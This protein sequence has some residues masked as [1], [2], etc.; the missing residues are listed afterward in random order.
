MARPNRR[1]Q[2][3]P[4]PRRRINPLPLV[5]AGL[6]VLGIIGLGWLAQGNGGGPSSPADSSG[7]DCQHWC[8]S[9]TA[10][11]SYGGTSASITGGGCY[12]TGASGV[13][14]RFGDWQGLEGVSD[15][16]QLIIFTPGVPTPTPDENGQLPTLVTGSIDGNPFVLGND[17][18]VRYSPDGT[19]SFSGTDVNGGGEATGTFTCR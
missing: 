4:A 3:A 5:L 1:A 7:T 12:D 6:V 17:A 9:G 10:T 11:V 15:Y 19:G 2:P 16:L 14:A 8:G 18:V 13:D